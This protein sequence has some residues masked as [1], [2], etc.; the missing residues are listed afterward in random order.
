M[1]PLDHLIQDYE[2]NVGPL[3]ETH[4]ADWWENVV[5]KNLMPPHYSHIPKEELIKNCAV[6]HHVWTEKEIVELLEYLELKIIFVDPK[7]YDRRDSFVV[8]A[9]K[10]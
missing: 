8:I 4:F 3:D 5:E 10:A 6:H 9:E 2:N 7:V 1:T